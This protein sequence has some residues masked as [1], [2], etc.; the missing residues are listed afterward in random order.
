M[1]V[2]K[3]SLGANVTDYRENNIKK[4][5]F[6]SIKGIAGF[7]SSYLYRRHFFES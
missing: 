3:L 2:V 7:K 1:R 4:C 6:A 5:F